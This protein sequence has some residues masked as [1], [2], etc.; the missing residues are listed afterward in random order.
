M[1][2][3]L[4]QSRTLLASHPDIQ[5]ELRDECRGI[6]SH[7]RGELPN[8]MELKTMKFLDNVLKEGIQPS[9]PSYLFPKNTSSDTSNLY[10]P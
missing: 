5:Q 2:I 9:T 1:C 3:A 7:C 10:S 6:P 8:A 4:T